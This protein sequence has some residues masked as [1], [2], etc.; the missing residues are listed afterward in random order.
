MAFAVAV[1]TLSPLPF[2]LTVFLVN[3]EFLQIIPLEGALTGVG[4]GGTLFSPRTVLAVA[5]F[6]TA[7]LWGIGSCLLLL[8]RQTQVPG[9][10]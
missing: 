7:A 9:R 6:A 4:V 5:A 1:L 3:Q 8:F 2:A 10:R